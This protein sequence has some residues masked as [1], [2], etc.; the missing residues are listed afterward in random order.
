MKQARWNSSIDD[1]I[2]PLSMLLSKPLS[3]LGLKR[4][5]TV[6]IAYCA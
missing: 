6:L 1:V 5:A 2:R 3:H 4:V